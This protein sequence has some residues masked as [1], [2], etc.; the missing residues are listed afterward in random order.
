[1]IIGKLKKI[2]NERVML[3]D[4]S[5]G[6]LIQQMKLTEED[7]RGEQFKNH[8]CDLKGNVDILC[9]TQP[10][11]IKNIHKVYLECGA[12]ITETNTFSATSVAQADY[13]MEH[14][15]YKIN[16]EAA[17]LAKEA[18]DEIM[19]QD[20]SKPR[21]V[22]GS[23]GPTNKT[24]SISPDVNDPGFRAI[25]F[26]QLYKSYKEQVR[27]L[28]DGGVDLFLVETIFDTLNAK[29]AIM[30]IADYSEEINK[31]LPIM[32]SGT[33]TDASGRTLTGQLPEAFYISLKHAKNLISVG[34]NCALGAK[35]LRPYIEELSG[36]AECYV[37]V[38]PN[39]GLPNE[40]GEYDETP[41]TMADTL[42]EFIDSGFLN[43]VGGCCG[44]G[45]EH[46]KAFAKMIENKTPR[47]LPDIP[48]YLR[49]SGLEPLVI[50]PESI[51]LNIGERTNVAGS[52]KFARLIREEKFE[53]ALS[54]A[55]HQVENGAQVIDINMDDAMLDAKA[56]MVKFLNLIASEPDIAKVPVM[57]D[58][59]KW[60]VIEA[61]LKCLQ[62]KGIVNS[63]SLK[64]GEQQFIEHARKI[65]GYGASAV[66]MAFDEK[67]Q[68]DSFE[69]KIKICERAY[70]ILTEKVQ[71]PPEDIIFDPN[72]FAVATG[73]KEHNNYAV[74]YINATKWIKKNLPYAKIS[75]GVSNLS[76]S[77]RGN[78]H[79]REAMHS[80][81]LYHAISAGMDMGIVNAGQ[82]EV[83]EE[84]EPDLL[85]L[86]ED[87]VLNRS[88][89]ATDK[90][91]EYAESHKSDKSKK[92]EETEVWRKN[93][94]E[95]RLRHAM[96][97]GIMDYIDEDVEEARQKYPDPLNII[98]GPLMDGMNMVGELFGAGKMFLPQVV[99]SARVMKKAVA[100][101]IP[102]IEEQKKSSGKSSA[103]KVLLATVKGDVHDI[104]KN[105]V[106]V[107]LGCNNYEV[108]DLGVMVPTDKI[109]EEA[110]KQNVDIIGLS[111]LITPSLEEM[112]HVASELERKGIKKP[113]LI[114]GATTSKKHTALKIAPNY[115]GI[116]LHVMDASKSVKAVSSLLKLET[117]EEIRNNLQNEYERLK[118]E[119]ARKLNGNNYLPI[120][121]ARKNKLQTNW[122]SA[123]IVKPK[124]L[125]ITVFNDFS[126]E[127]IIPYIDWS[128]FFMA[129]ELRGKYPS[130]FDS[131]KY[132]E[133][134]K[135]LFEDAQDLLK[136]ILDKKLL[137][138]NAV[139][140]L[141]PANSTNNDDIE[142]YEDESAK[143]VIAKFHTLRQQKKME[144]GKPNLALSDYIAPKDSGRIDYIGGFAATA[145]LNIEKAIADFEKNND[146][147]NSIMIKTLA[148]R[149]AEAF[150][151]LIHE[152]VRKEIWGYAS[153]EN[154]SKEDLL[155]M[156]FVGIRPAQGYPAQPD[157]SEKQQLFK[158]LNVEK[159]TGMQ[160]T[161]S[162]M[163]RPGASVCG[164]YFA[165]PESKYFD[166]GKLNKDQII[167]YSF[168][169]GVP[170]KEIEKYLT[171][172]LNYTK[173][174]GAK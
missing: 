133:A 91:I 117:R 3:L 1:M 129:W 170:T 114:G 164:L 74:D 122:E 44:T 76:F 22:A 151:E 9:L 30:A 36:I 23:M 7:Y 131:P 127:E 56:S 148:D 80:V 87:V 102:Y 79:V 113:L 108:I 37:S 137:T 4:G 55:N 101:L 130:I 146:D 139:I 64:E 165:Y 121:S 33:I 35:Q 115:S 92:S 16:F 2:L 25:T 166:V 136:V 173:N 38:H 93:S 46:I 5:Y 94:V 70:K 98:E 66:V 112:T 157:H 100:I 99:K 34:L 18:A 58:S 95:E 96:V 11:K 141:F 54:I 73:L 51:F 67:G 144:N 19:K 152:K 89:N 61:G 8:P 90:L 52:R 26:D 149:L 161:D 10:D 132:G 172:N 142:I 156:K 72:I 167:D 107:V 27:G 123:E 135:K 77:F 47:K 103:G 174:N 78:N 126:L 110:E 43:I 163:I 31:D 14:L 83:Y 75:G 62:G 68:A 28:V 50:T 84:I 106:S 160:L 169:K 45:P 138:A 158:L 71:F 105:I 147:Y 40:M 39:A 118:N 29:A 143:K 21:F 69:R 42:E 12:D 48:K 124:K 125:G 120:N 162:F 15:V 116:T 109:I 119:F 59:S 153:N 20:P 32:L 49:L 111:G 150:T 6:V 24:T 13:Q 140:G 81:F 41:E 145:G 154:L 53:E 159:T 82:L 60:E 57:I 128:F 104:G 63:I 171:T 17:R 65:K 88:E 85:K 86:V 97:K 134:A 168:R 155:K